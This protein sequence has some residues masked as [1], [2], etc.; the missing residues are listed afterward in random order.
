MTSRF[1]AAS[2]G[3]IER[4]HK[5]ANILTMLSPRLGSA[6]GSRDRGDAEDVSE[7]AWN[8]ILSAQEGSRDDK[9]Q[10]TS[11]LFDRPLS[12]EPSA[13]NEADGLSQSLK[14]SSGKISQSSGKSRIRIQY[15][16][17]SND[18]SDL[19]DDSAE[20]DEK[21]RGFKLPGLSQT[22]KDIIKCGLAYFIASLFTYNNRLSE[23]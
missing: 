18:S 12:A 21:H 10:S 1:K 7:S 22:H 11:L 6:F 14:S 13:L 3:S 5:P 19:S 20:D 15:T 8:D 2:D 16:A 23:L 17:V 4:K 9:E